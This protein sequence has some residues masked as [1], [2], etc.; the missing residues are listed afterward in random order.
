MTIPFKLE[1]TK[2]K[3]VWYTIL[4]SH[5]WRLTIHHPTTDVH[6]YVLDRHSYLDSVLCD[7]QLSSQFFS[8]IDPRIALQAERRLQLVQI[9]YG[10]QSTAAAA[11]WWRHRHGPGRTVDVRLIATGPV[12][13]GKS[14]IYDYTDPNMVYTLNIDGIEYN[15]YLQ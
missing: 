2:P 10:E 14:K 1:V 3:L 12:W 4:A 15:E 13:L 5:Q 9:R 7:S 11:A 8:L 6:V